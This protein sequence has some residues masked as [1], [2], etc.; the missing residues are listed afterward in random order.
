M[1][2]K[3]LSFAVFI[4]FVFCM[5]AADDSSVCLAASSPDYCGDKMF[6]KRIRQECEGTVVRGSG[7]K[8]YISPK[9]NDKGN[10]SKSRPFRTFSAALKKL[11]PGDTLYVR[12]GT[13]TEN[14]VIPAKCSGTA[15]KYIT[16]CNYSGEKAVI[17]GKS[18]KS[19]VLLTVDGASYLRVSGLEFQNASGQDACGISVTAGSHHVIL[20]N[21]TMH[22]IT[23]KDPYKED[24]CANG[25]LLFGDSSKKSIHD[26]LIY[27]NEIYDCQTGWAECISVTGN[28]KNINVVDNTI[29]NTGNIGIDFSGNYGYCSDPSKDFPR[30]GFI[31]KNKVSNC[32]SQYATSYGIY[33]DGGQNITI[34]SNQVSGCSGGIEIGAERKAPKDKYSVSNIRVLENTIKNNRENGITVGGYKKNLGWVKNVKIQNN[35]CR[36]NGK[37]NAIVT[38]AKCDGV[39]LQGNTFCNTSGSAAVIYSEFGSGYTKNIVFKNNKYSNGNKKNKTCFVYLGKTYSSFDKWKKVVGKDAGSYQE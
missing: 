22:D 12:K 20:A 26:V 23:V 36:N 4:L 35:V 7:K 31:Y 2:K 9:G 25:I 16:I 13:Y 38:L 30:N 1:K 14:I 11:K 17:S 37:T 39:V 21:H 24:H 5:L 28:C 33:V 8:Y 29:K 19:P 34:Q 32:V 3:F 10:G 18:Q 6:V 15:D 27:G